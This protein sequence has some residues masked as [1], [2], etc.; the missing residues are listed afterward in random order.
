M[1]YPSS[2]DHRDRGRWLAAGGALY[3]AAA[4][5]LAAYATHVLAGPDQARLQAA[6]VFA[7]GHGV[8]IAA[9]APGLRGRLGRAAL[10]GLWL[11]V[12]LFAGS[13]VGKAVAGWPLTLAPYGGSLAIASWLVFALDRLRR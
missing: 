9:L 5:A 2:Y 6:A 3:A 10:S 7:F 4:V 1:H 8:A 13:L 11:A 12:L